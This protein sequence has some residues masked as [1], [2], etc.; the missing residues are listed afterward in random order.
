MRLK[1]PYRK[2]REFEWKCRKLLEHAGYFVVRQAKSAFPD[3]IA[4]NGA[5]WLLIECKVNGKI[6]RK[7]VEELLKLA[8]W[9]NAKAATMQQTKE[10]TCLSFLSPPTPQ[11]AIS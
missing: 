2:G 6:S 8:A 11:K 7:E 3:L 1:N 9:T 10:G 5:G 4:S